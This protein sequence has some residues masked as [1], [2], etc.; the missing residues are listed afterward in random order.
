MKV[1]QK[2]AIVTHDMFYGVPHALRDYLLNKKLEKLVFIGHPLVEQ[3]KS[4]IAVYKRGELIY[5]RYITQRVYGIFSYIFDFFLTIFWVMKQ[6]EKYNMFIAVDSL[7]AFTGL[8]LRRTGIVKRVVFYAMDFNPIRFN[9]FLL[10]SIFHKIEEVCVRNSDEAWNVSP[11]IAEGR[12]KFLSISQKKYPQKVVN[13]GIWINKIKQFPFEKV[14]K[15]QL[16]FLGHLL[17][18]QGLQMVLEATQLVIKQIPDFKF[19]IL[20]GGEYENNLKNIAKELSIE[21]YVEFKGWVSERKI[22]DTTLGESA[23][24]IAVYVPE[25]EK[26]YNFSYYGDPIKLKEY[27]AS[28]LPV[29]LT[30]VPHNAKEIARRKCGIV[31]EYKKEDIANAIVTIL[32]DEKKLKE[33]RHNAVKYAKEFDWNII[34]SNVLN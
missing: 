2:I 6:R 7:N 27:F 18:K 13:S 10:N 8:V 14:K 12:E 25:K 23:A 31:V 22:I 21:K 1:D 17:K 19:V 20:G 16:L 3:R 32:K 9:N 5:Q 26:L 34:F 30:D 28:G 11:K 29:I 33:Y 4:S 15:H 24:A